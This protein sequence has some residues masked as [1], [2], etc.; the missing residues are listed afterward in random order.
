[1]SEGPDGVMPPA[2]PTTP[3]ALPPVPLL[4]P[5]WPR[6]LGIIGIVMG[7]YGIATSLLGV[8]RLPERMMAGPP[9]A[10]MPSAVPEGLQPWMRSLG[11][12]SMLLAALLLAASIGLLCRRGWSVRAL[13]LWAGMK[14]GLVVVSTVLIA[15]IVAAGMPTQAGPPMSPWMMNVVLVA[16]SCVGLPIGLAIPVFTLIWFSRRKIKDE[17]ANWG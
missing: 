8:L 1:M 7:V 3:L 4:P 17:V 11:A 9:T 6:V 12:A 5:Q 15:Q 13:L 2:P 14:A 10:S 16:G